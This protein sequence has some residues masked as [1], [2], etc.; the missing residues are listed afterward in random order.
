MK[1]IIVHIRKIKEKRK[2][3]I[4]D[5]VDEYTGE[6][7]SIKRTKQAGWLE[8]MQVQDCLTKQQICSYLDN[9]LHLFNDNEKRK[10]YK[11]E[12]ISWHFKN[13]KT[14]TYNPLVK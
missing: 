2:T 10:T 7:V 13:R 6:V 4:E 12:W 9:Q 5:F 8:T 3:W 11:R 14:E 1:I